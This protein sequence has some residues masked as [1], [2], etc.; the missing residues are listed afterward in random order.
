MMFSMDKSDTKG[1]KGDILEM[2]ITLIKGEDF[3]F[4]APIQVN[5]TP[6]RRPMD[7]MPFLTGQDFLL[8]SG[9]DASAAV[10]IQKSRVESIEFTLA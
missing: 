7:L 8:I 4:D 3:S 9:E 6:V 5:G 1:V 2:D 10:I